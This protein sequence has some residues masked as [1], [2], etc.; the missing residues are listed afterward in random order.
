MPSRLTIFV[1]CLILAGCDI[2]SL[3]HHSFSWAVIDERAVTQKLTEIA[4][5]QNPYP[6][7]LQNLDALNERKRKLDRQISDLKRQAT[8]RCVKKKEK[9][10]DKNSSRTLRHPAVVFP[11]QVNKG[12][13]SQR[14]CLS[15]INNDPL[16]MDLSDKK[17]EINKLYKQKRVHDQKIRESVKVAVKAVIK[18]RFKNEFDLVLTKRDNIILYNQSSMIVDVTEKLLEHI[19][20]AEITITTK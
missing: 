8:D 16:I 18:E 2:D 19:E 14:G 6:E 17:S 1:F 9:L 10:S 3:F 12:F 20:I 11:P 15:E 7:E 4:N 5:T 13:F